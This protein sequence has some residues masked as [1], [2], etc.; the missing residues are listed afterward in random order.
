MALFF[1]DSEDEPSPSKRSPNE[2]RAPTKESKLAKNVDSKKSPGKKTG[3]KRRLSPGSVD[4]KMP[5]SKRIST[6]DN[7]DDSHGDKVSFE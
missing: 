2:N 5:A 3:A 4:E 7:S 6:V 1:F